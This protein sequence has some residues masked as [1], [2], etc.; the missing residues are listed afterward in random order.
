M[1]INRIINVFRLALVLSI[2][3]GLLIFVGLGEARRTYP[4]FAIEKLAAQGELVQMAMKSFLLADLPLNQYPGFNTVTQPILNSDATIAAIYVTNIPG[5]VVFS[6]GVEAQEIGSPPGNVQADQTPSQ[7]QP[8]DSRYQVMENEQY[9]Q[10]QFELRNRFDQVGT[11]HIV[12]PKSFVQGAINEA[13]LPVQAGA[14]IVVCLY[15]IFLFA[16]SSRWMMSEEEEEESPLLRP[17]E[18]AKQATAVTGWQQAGVQLLSI[19]YGVSFLIVA[20]LVIY[21][22][23]NIYQ[24][25]IRGKIRALTDSLGY[26][27]NTAMDV[28]L[29]IEDFTGIEQVFGEYRTLNPDLSYV[30]LT[31]DNNVILH[32]DETVIGSS[33]QAPRDHFEEKAL[34][35]QDASSGAPLAL[36]LGVQKSV[37]YGRL[38]TS[39]R[40]FVALFVATAFLSSLFF[41]LIRSMSNRP[42]LLPGTLRKQRGFLLSLIGPFYFLSI[43]VI[44]GLAAAF[45]PQYFKSLA[46]ASGIQTDVATLFS[47]YYVTYTIALFVTARPADKYG[48]K[49]FLVIGGGLIAIELLLLSF[50][51]NFYAMYL[52]QAITGLGEGMLFNAV[53]SF[54]IRVASQRQRTRGAG[55]IV[56]SLYGGWLSGTAIGSLLA[57]DPAFG[58]RGVFLLGSVIAA[59]NLIYV[60]FALPSLKGEHFEETSTQQ[61]DSVTLQPTMITRDDMRREIEREQRLRQAKN[62]LQRALLNFWIQASAS[63]TDFE[64]L[65]TA[66]LIGVPVKVIVAGLFKASLPLVLTRLNY[67]TEDVGQILMLYFGGVLLSSAIITRLTD[68]MGNTR[69]ILFM[70]GVGSGIGLAL[71]GLIGLESLATS[72]TTILLLAGM[73]IL[74]LAHGFIQAPIVTH[75]SRTSTAKNLGQSTASSIYRLYERIG[76]IGGPLL[77]GAILIQT[78]YDAFTITMIGATVAVFGL[79]FIPKLSRKP[80]AVKSNVK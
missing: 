43:F 42:R 4:R 41:S 56:T 60:A 12:L 18:S 80:A 40:N 54:I 23:T 35:Q 34:L 21:T 20:L 45:L 13:F 16:T 53:F 52:V 62:P 8:E 1:T 44:H 32:T 50:V 28:G 71:M 36:H 79:F 55:I 15:M 61:F 29:S 66:V 65:R 47:V 49:P 57:A 5:Q 31:Q 58:L 63:L 48:A 7:V 33:W 39:A 9:Y 11:L 69:L 27:L 17:G 46:E 73:V 59:L 38:L 74:G 68:K 70:G 26:R 76:N 64:F 10:V 25:G 37:V 24:D 14:V 3:L 77:I 78:N 67:P 22:L 2:S 30:V 51:R 72:A 19:S 6:N 75:I